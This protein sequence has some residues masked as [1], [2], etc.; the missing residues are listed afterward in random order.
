MKNNALDILFAHLISTNVDIAFITETWFSDTN[1]CDAEVSCS[2]KFQVFRR[3]R[4][5]RGGGVLILVKSALTCVPVHTHLDDDIELIVVDLIINNRRIR[6]VCVY[7]SPTGSTDL[8]VDRMN[9]LCCVL[10][11]LCDSDVSTYI[12]GDFNLPL[13]DWNNW[14]CPGKN[15]VTKESIFLEF[16]GKLGLNQLVDRPTRLKSGNLLDLVLCNDGSIDFVHLYNSPFVS[17][18]S[19]V[20]FCINILSDDTHEKLR[21]PVTTFDYSKGDFEFIKLN[22]HITNWF[23]FFSSCEN[24]DDMYN[25]FVEYM[26][27]L[28]S[29]FV[30]QY[31]IKQRHDVDVFIT[32]LNYKIS[33]ESDENNL[34]KL[35]R[36]LEKALRRKRIIEENKV[37]NSRDPKKFYNYVATRMNS[38]DHLS[39]L[40]DDEGN[41]LTDDLDKAELL[42]NYFES[43]YPSLGQVQQR[44]NN[45]GPTL[46][47]DPKIDVVNQVDSSPSNL[48]KFLRRLNNSKSMTPD[49]LPST[50]LK[51]CGYEVCVPLSLILE[52]TLQDGQLPQLFKCA[53]I[54]P[55]HKKG[56][57]SRV[58]NKRNVSLTSSC[59]KLFESIICDV[60]FSNA[61]SQGLICKDQ[62]AYR[63]GYSCTLQLLM[64][65]NDFAEMLNNGDCFDVIYFDFKSAFEL[66]THSKLLECFESLGVGEVLIRWIS[67]FLSDRTFKVS[68]NNQLSSEAKI[69][70]GCPQ[71]TILGCIAYIFYTN[72]IK[73]VLP[74]NVKVKIYA[75]DT[76]IY[77]R[78]NNVND[79]NVLQDAVN[80]FYRWTVALDLLLSV[81]KCNVLHHGRNNQRFTYFIDNQQ[82]MPVNSVRDL[83]IILTPDLKFSEQT[84]EVVNKASRRTNFILR[85]FTINKPEV[86]YKLFDVYI[87][88]ILTYGSPVWNPSLKKDIKLLQSVYNKFR[89]KVAYKCNIHKNDVKKLIVTDILENCDKK[90]FLS[91]VEKSEFC[92]EFFN[93]VFTRT[94]NPCK[95]RPKFVARTE[96]INNLFPWRVTRLMNVNPVDPL[97]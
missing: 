4:K 57:K 51:M 42:K 96:T 53:I 75:D 65:Q 46:Y 70:S 68:V 29:S 17:D 3:D 63:R 19:V 15:T 50:F 79:Y 58:E 55:I 89:R 80:K 31:V 33:I 36:D 94:R 48:Y 86:Y 37:V 77:A 14:Q 2:D 27:F 97:C 73:H 13:I 72:S 49:G 95:H 69:T 30:P 76:K 7:F 81:G 8:L 43:T 39:V 61:I 90:M 84:R 59:C 25:K 83:G 88:P 56:D 10:E 32:K 24:V 44:D 38:K 74:E 92:N 26:Y 11:S 52:R 41:A 16:C 9:R 45:P 54:I 82:I 64:C 18:H 1:V 20:N 91:I 28:R 60:I 62:Y 34:V 6:C 35:R 85:S 71:G 23:V 67:S 12:V 78:V 93:Y 5:T 87:L 66:T 47:C 21:D 22:L 40:T